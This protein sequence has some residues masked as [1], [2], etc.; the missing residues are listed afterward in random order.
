MKIII[1]FAQI[2]HKLKIIERSFY[3]RN[4]SFNGNGNDFK[5]LIIYIEGQK[6]N[7]AILIPDPKKQNQTKSIMHPY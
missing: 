2:L 3:L 6:V 7:F 4:W 1:E 5:S